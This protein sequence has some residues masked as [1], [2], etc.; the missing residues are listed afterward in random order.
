MARGI[1]ID[2]SRIPAISGDAARIV[3]SGYVDTASVMSPSR[4]GIETI[5]V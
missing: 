1:R 5:T 2:R 4:A 3:L